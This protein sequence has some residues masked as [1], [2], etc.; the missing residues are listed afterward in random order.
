MLWAQPVAILQVS[1]VQLSLSSHETVVATAPHCPALHRRPCR[2]GEPASTRHSASAQA[3]PSFCLK[4]WQVLPVASGTQRV[5][6]HSPGLSTASHSASVLQPPV[7]SPLAS[8]SLVS[9]AISASS[10]AVVSVA[11]AAS[12][13]VAASGASVGVASA[14]SSPSLCATSYT[15]SCGPLLHPEVAANTALVANPHIQGKIFTAEPLP[16]DLVGRRRYFQS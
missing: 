3:M 14:A 8:V 16:A 4:S 13:A 15:Y 10:S 9:A 1:R 6:S 11:G 2:I 7:V 12:V 5:Y